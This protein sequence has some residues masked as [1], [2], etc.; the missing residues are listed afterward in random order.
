MDL[1]EAIEILKLH[2]DWRKGADTEQLHP[3][4]IGNAI[5]LVIKTISELSALL[6][7]SDKK[8]KPEIPGDRIDQHN[9]WW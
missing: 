2:N 3:V 4:K 9:K 5:D 1:K 7:L 6:D 8:Q